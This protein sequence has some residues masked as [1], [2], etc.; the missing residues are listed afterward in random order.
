[1]HELYP[2][3]IFCSCNAIHARVEV[4]T[5]LLATGMGGSQCIDKGIFFR[6]TNRGGL[7]R[8]T[9]R[10]SKLVVGIARWLQRRM[11]CFSGHGDAL[12]I[13]CDDDNEDET[14]SFK[15][16]DEEG[17]DNDDTST[18]SNYDSNDIDNDDD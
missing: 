18:D 7:A 15:D 9:A 17:N 3:A 12:F 11:M 10:K 16:N 6:R 13:K 14:S 2:C 1:M 5:P 8:N 4:P